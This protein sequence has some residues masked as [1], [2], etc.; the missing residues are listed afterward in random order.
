MSNQPIYNNSKLKN[1]GKYDFENVNNINR[2]MGEMQFD[3]SIKKDNKKQIRKIVITS[4]ISSILLLAT[5]IFAFT[6]IKYLFF[7]KKVVVEENNDFED[8]N[9]LHELSCSIVLEQEGLSIS[10]DKLYEYNNNKIKTVM[11]TYIIDVSNEKLINDS[12]F[13]EYMDNS[14]NEIK[15][16][17][18]NINGVEITYTSEETKYKLIQK[19]DL[20]V[21]DKNKV[22]N[23]FL[24][25]RLDDDIEKTKANQINAG[26]KCK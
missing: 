14:L 9:V 2:R 23:E 20:R 5:I 25:V 26:L 22:S 11:Y 3:S 16:K 13:F 1:A 24:D 4:I 21:I 6:D 7:P 18:N 17:Y 19:T 12:S 10:V 8:L 15:N